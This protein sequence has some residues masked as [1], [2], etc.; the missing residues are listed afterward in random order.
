[1]LKQRVGIQH[2]LRVSVQQPASSF[3]RTKL[4]VP[5]GRA[6]LGREAAQPRL[7]TKHWHFSVAKTSCSRVL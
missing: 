6:N 4:S 5:Q 7:H 1:M 3:V 2:L